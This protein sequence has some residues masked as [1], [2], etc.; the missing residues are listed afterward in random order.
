MPCWDWG[1]PPSPVLGWQ[2]RAE[3]AGA[4]NAQGIADLEATEGCACAKN[5]THTHT[6]IVP[7]RGKVSRSSMGEGT[8]RLNMTANIIPKFG[9]ILIKIFGF[10][11]LDFF[12][13]FFKRM[14][15]IPFYVF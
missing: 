4:G 14:E 13:S 7:S 2:G 6:L 1:L 3:T 10:Q 11:L 9:M 5:N 8:L 12:F 15:Q